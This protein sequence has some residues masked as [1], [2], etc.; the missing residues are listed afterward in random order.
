MGR[1]LSQI[2]SILPPSFLGDS[3][4]SDKPQQVINMTARAF[5]SLYFTANACLNAVG[6]TPQSI[7]IQSHTKIHGNLLKRVKC[8]DFFLSPGPSK[9]PFTHP[10]RYVRNM[11]Y[12]FAVVR[13]RV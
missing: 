7:R 3:R 5:L 12:V 6:G 11:K 13:W 8:C 2:Q 4:T 1:A 9:H 10:D